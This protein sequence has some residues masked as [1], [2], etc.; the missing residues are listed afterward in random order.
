MR[1]TTVL[2]AAALAFAGTASAHDYKAG[3][4]RIAHPYATPSIAGAPH[5]AA[6]MA[7]LE[8]TGT[9]PDR[10]LRAST[11]AAARVELHTMSLDGG[12]MRMREVEAIPLAA[13]ETLKM[14]PGQGFHLMLMQLKAPLKVG[15]TFPLVLEFEKGGKVEMRVDVQQPRESSAAHKH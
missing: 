2:A 12:V 5:G 4:I 11:P 8:N 13:K 15:D 10:L 6:Y 9:A 7:T 1:L 3:S 14:R